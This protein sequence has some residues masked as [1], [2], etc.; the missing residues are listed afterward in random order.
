MDEKASLTVKMVLA[1]ETKDSILTS[2]VSKDIETFWCR[3][4]EESFKNIMV[5]V[6]ANSL[7]KYKKKGVILSQQVLR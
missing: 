7:M 3:I 1:A 2:K 4:S 5:Y 6:K